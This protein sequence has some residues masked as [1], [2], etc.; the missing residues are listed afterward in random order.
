M[1]IEPPSHQSE[2]DHHATVDCAFYIQ[3]PKLHRTSELRL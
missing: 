3:S 2:T 1:Q